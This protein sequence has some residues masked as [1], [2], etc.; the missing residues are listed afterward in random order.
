LLLDEPTNDLDL[1]S[2]AALEEFLADFKGV[3]VVVSHDRYF[4]DQVCNRFL[5]LDGRGKVLSWDGSVEDY[6]K[7]EASQ[8][9]AEALAQSKAQETAQ[10]AMDKKT[11][12]EKSMESE[13][14]PQE[15]DQSCGCG[16]EKAYRE[17]GG[18]AEEGGRVRSRSKYIC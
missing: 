4:L 11:E 6:V 2:I 18:D 1:G 5:V 14:K 13:R 15:V 10:K 16:V 8:K 3:L 9:K 7:Y 12:K 17:A